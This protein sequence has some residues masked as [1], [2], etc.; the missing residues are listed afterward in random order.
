M[1]TPTFKAG[2][3]VWAWIDFHPDTR[4]PKPRHEDMAR[5]KSINR[6]QGTVLVMLTNT[7][8]QDVPA[9]V[10]LEDIRPR[11]LPR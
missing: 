11:E 6:D 1:S 10:L 5:I 7:N 8:M 2:Q 4:A 9:L 3:H